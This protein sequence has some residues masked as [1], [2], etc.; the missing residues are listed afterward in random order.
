[1][2]IC[3]MFLLKVILEMEKK[4]GK[5][6]WLLEAPKKALCQS[7]EGKPIITQLSIAFLR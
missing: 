1:M 2:N 7:L 6:S 4:N 5:C 3:C